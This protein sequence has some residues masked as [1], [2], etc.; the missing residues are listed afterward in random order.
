[1]LEYLVVVAVEWEPA[2]E[3]LAAAVV[4]KSEAVEDTK[5]LTGIILTC[6]ADLLYDGSFRK[7]YQNRRGLRKWFVASG[8]G[9]RAHT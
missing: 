6:S 2:L 1:M 7:I 4:V 5:N 8:N 3:A 9:K